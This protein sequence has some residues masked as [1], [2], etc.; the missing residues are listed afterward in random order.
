MKRIDSRN[1]KAAWPRRGFALGLVVGLP[2]S[3][4]LWLAIVW[5][6]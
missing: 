1:S 2:I 5:A 6:F 3:L 4:A